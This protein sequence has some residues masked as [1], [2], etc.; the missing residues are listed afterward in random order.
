MLFLQTLP[1][2]LIGSLIQEKMSIYVAI[3]LTLVLYI[4]FNL[5]KLHYLV[6]KLLL[7]L[8]LTLSLLLLNFYLTNV[9]YSPTFHLNIISVVKHCHSLSCSLNFSFDQCVIQDNKSLRMIGFAKQMDGLYKY[10]P[11]SSE[12]KLVSSCSINKSCNS[13]IQSYSNSRNVITSYALWNSD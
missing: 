12:S 7:C 3:F 4:Q 13:T 11:A 8:M 10:L 1:T 5:L 9:L 2:I 6:V